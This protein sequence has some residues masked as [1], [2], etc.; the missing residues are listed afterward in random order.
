MQFYLTTVD[1]QPKTLL[2]RTKTA[3]QAKSKY[4]LQHLANTYKNLCRVYLHLFGQEFESDEVEEYIG[5]YSNSIL[6]PKRQCDMCNYSFRYEKD[7]EKH[8]LNSHSD[9][10]YEELVTNK[11][12]KSVMPKFFTF[13]KEGI[14]QSK[15]DIAM[16]RIRTRWTNFCQIRQVIKG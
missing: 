10:K 12:I 5:F 16:M 14:L 2:F 9:Q 3:C 6:G 8:K 13:A 4:S 7:L 15:T 11:S 1:F